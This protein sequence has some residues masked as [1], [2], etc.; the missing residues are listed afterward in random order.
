MI[1]GLS[2]RGRRKL[3]TRRWPRAGGLVVHAHCYLH[4]PSLVPFGHR[5]PVAPH[6]LLKLKSGDAIR[7]A[8]PGSA[9]HAARVR[10][11]PAACSPVPGIEGYPLRQRAVQE[12]GDARRYARTPCPPSAPVREA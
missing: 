12:P 4:R 10:E 7:Q 6:Y 8:R 2:G 1:H 11:W 3:L 9:R 5:I